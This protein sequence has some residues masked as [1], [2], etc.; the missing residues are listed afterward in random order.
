MS[1]LGSAGSPVVYNLTLNEQ[2]PQ[3]GQAFWKT[4]TDDLWFLSKL[5][6]FFEV[7]HFIFLFFCKLHPFLSVIFQGLNSGSSASMTLLPD[8]F[9]F[10][11]LYLLNPLSLL[12]FYPNHHLWLSSPSTPPE[13]H[14]LLHLSLLIAWDVWP[15]LVLI[16]KSSCRPCSLA[17]QRIMTQESRYGAL[18][19]IAI[20]VFSP[21]IKFV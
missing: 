15:R 10:Y 5:V 8:S 12:C 17:R 9:M 4:D 19:Y 6:S 11:I 21:K 13:L 2:N 3:D 7:L 1:E 16:V 20:A 18:G 14:A